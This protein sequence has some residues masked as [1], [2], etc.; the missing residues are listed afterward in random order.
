MTAAPFSLTGADERM[1]RI[2]AASAA[3][4]NSPAPML[5]LAGAALVLATVFTLWSVGAARSAGRRLDAAVVSRD[6]VERVIADIEGFRAAADSARTD[7]R[8]SRQL[9]LSTLAAINQRVGLP[10]APSI[11]EQRPRVTPDS[12]LAKRQVDIT[13]N[14]AP[15]PAALEWIHEAQR[16]VPG[17]FV[18]ALELRPTPTGWT[19][20]VQVARWEFRL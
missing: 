1:V 14:N 2:H 17:L 10:S 12:P 5:L 8:Y 11:Q 15:L 13:M 20:R 7:G 6:G 3:R 9:Q 4:R 16:S 18:S 19:V